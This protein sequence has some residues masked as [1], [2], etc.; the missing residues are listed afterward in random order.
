[1]YCFHQTV[2]YKAPKNPELGSDVGRVQKEEQRKIDD[3]QPLSDE[4][5][6][7]KEKLLTQGFTNWTKRNFNQFIKANEN[8]GRDDNDNITKEIEGKKPEEVMEYSIVFWER[9]H[10]L[11][12][13]GK[14]LMKFN[15]IAAGKRNHSRETK[16]PSII[17]D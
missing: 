2:G 17:L 9:C 11:Q 7:E 13:I 3:A 10:E 1:M 5:V 15:L 12:D 8:Y 16:V 14:K 4:E 6:D